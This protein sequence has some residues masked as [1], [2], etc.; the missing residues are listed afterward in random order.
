[1][2]YASHILLMRAISYPVHTLFAI[3]Y[4]DRAFEAGVKTP[5]R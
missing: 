5:Q 2:L 4:L 1:M 3:H